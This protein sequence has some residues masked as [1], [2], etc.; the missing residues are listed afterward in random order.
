METEMQEESSQQ[1]EQ[2][3]TGTLSSCH[4][5]QGPRIWDPPLLLSPIPSLRDGTAA[6]LDLYEEGVCSLSALLARARICSLM[7]SVVPAQ[8]S[9]APPIPVLILPWPSQVG[10]PERGPAGL[11]SFPF[12]SEWP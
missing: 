7:I 9:K 8:L 3:G 12:L 1:A 10:T 2:V 5:D 4:H 6:T 11:P